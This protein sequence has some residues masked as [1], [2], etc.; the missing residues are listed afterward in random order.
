[1]P[2]TGYLG[3]I[4]D[5]LTFQ[6]QGELESQTAKKLQIKLSDHLLWTVRKRT[7]KAIGIIILSKSEKRKL[8]NIILHLD[9]ILVSS[10]LYT[11]H[12][13]DGNNFWFIDYVPKQLNTE[14]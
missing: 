11:N 13:L 3:H 10:T 9:K 14:A 8:Q 5:T 4:L 12:I 6:R 7:V 2:F 1:M